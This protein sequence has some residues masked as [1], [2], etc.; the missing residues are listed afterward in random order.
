LRREIDRMLTERRR[1]TEEAALA[2]LS[3]YEARGL[4]TSGLAGV[5]E[6]ANRFLVSRLFLSARL[7]EPGYLCREHHFL[8][9]HE[10]RCP[11]CDQELLP[12]ENIVDELIEF[13]R[14]HGVELTVVEERPELL[15]PYG[16][17]AAVAY[18]LQPA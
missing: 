12:S 15:D 6:M 7:A 17:V 4:L 14:L 5:L 3:D 1:G 18:E 9:L 16:G 10:G 13:A 2:R 8:S 11:F